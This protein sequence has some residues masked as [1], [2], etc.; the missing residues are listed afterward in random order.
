MIK[1]GFL[2]L[3]SS[4]LIVHAEDNIMDFE[5]F[6]KHRSIMIDILIELDRKQKR[7]TLY[8][9]E[10]HFSLYQTKQPF[11][12]KIFNWNAYAL[13]GN[14]C[15]F[16]AWPSYIEGEFCKEP[17][18]YNM[19]SSFGISYDPQHYCGQRNMFRCN[20]I[21]FGNGD[22]EYSQDNNGN[23]VSAGKC[24]RFTDNGGSINNV[25]Q[26][27]FEATKNNLE[28]L[29]NRYLEDEEYR[30]QFHKYK[31]EVTLFC[32]LNP[33]YNA[34]SY[35]LD[36]V[37]KILAGATCIL[38]TKDS[39][40]MNSTALEPI[41]EV[42]QYLKGRNRRGRKV[43][44]SSSME[45]SQEGV[46]DLAPQTSVRP[47][48]P[49]PEF[50]ESLNNKSNGESCQF[51]N[52]FK[53]SGINE[54]ALKQ[55]LFYFENNRNELSKQRYISIADYGKNS[56]DKRFYILDLQTG[57]VRKE[58]VSHGSGMRK[59]RGQ[60]VRFGD[61]NHDGMLDRCHHKNNINDSM[62]LIGKSPGVNDE[63]KN[64][65]VVMHGAIYNNAIKMGRS[66]G[67]P[68]FKYDKAKSIINTIKEGSL[69]YSYIPQCEELQGLV[70]RQVRGWERM[71]D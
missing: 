39:L 13:E 22:G 71:C 40:T 6:E 16:G 45:H 51:F 43:S 52:N 44:S 18:K 59:V 17:W 29:Y 8:P 61:P 1:V 30:N 54:K 53:R 7:K 55:A 31:E 38:Q 48:A 46:S 65:Y 34:C 11:I 50:R 64:K 27:C 69:Y 24:I 5:S 49:S 57:K 63:A 21:L 9:I 23:G 67:C 66:Y 25:T 35:L 15:F 60:K 26:Q 41:Q 3:I 4:I 47:Q 19:N 36:Q 62:W 58:Q 56:R 70:D 14:L 28:A 68:A 10:G 33:F 20:P 37:D 12:Y 32:E 2:Y 42:S